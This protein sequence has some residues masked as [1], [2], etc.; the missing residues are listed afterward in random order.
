VGIKSTARKFGGRVKLGVGV[1]Y[2]LSLI[3][4]FIAVFHKVSS[5][6]YIPQVRGHIHPLPNVWIP[7]VLILPFAIHL[8]RQ[9]VSINPAD[10]KQALATFKA[11]K[12]TALILICSLLIM[13]IYNYAEIYG[14]FDSF[15]QERLIIDG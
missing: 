14:F 7:I 12:I 4:I 1:C 9:L 13:S 15:R 3:L 6:V 8:L 2:F 5:V 10:G 11:N